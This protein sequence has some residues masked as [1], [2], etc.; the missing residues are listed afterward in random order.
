M[1]HVRLTET[2][3]FKLQ[4]HVYENSPDHA[5]FSRKIHREFGPI[6]NRAPLNSPR[7][8]KSPASSKFSRFGGSTKS[9]DEVRSQLDRSLP[10]LVNRNSASKN[11]FHFWARKNSLGADTIE[12]GMTKNSSDTSSE[13]NLV[14]ATAFGGIMVSQE[15]SIDVRDLA[16]GEKVT[17]DDGDDEKAARK[18][19]GTSERLRI[20]TTGVASK[21][22]DDPE[23]Y[24]DKLFAV[25]VESR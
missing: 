14:E 6:L 4:Q 12:L 11:P 7:D 18:R 10:T 8:L 19:A 9:N 15:V 24:V 16:E 25:C 13:K 17:H 5:V 22:D 1:V 21:E 20:G 23:T 2:Q 3:F